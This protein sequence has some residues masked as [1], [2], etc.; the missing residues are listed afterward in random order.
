[1]RIP[2]LLAA[3]AAALGLLAGSIAA[4]S[5]AAEAAPRARW[6]LVA[7]AAAHAVSVVDASTGRITGA[8]PDAVLGTHAGVI[9]MGH[10]RVAF[11]DESGPRLD[12]VDITSSGVPRVASATP[13]PDAAGAW[14]RAGW[15]ADDPGHRFVA[16]G[17]DLDGSTTQQVT[18]LDTRRQLAR[19]ATIRTS[20][21]T[22]A[23]TG[24]R[25]TE[26]METFLVGS[27]L[28]LVVTAGGR[29]DAY[30]VAAILGGDA[31]PTPVATTPLGAYPHGPV[32]DARGT[33]IGSTLHDGIETVPLTRGGFG[34][35]LARPYPEPAVQSYRPRMAPDGETAVGT[36]TGTGPGAPTLLTSSSMRGAGVASV[37]LG[38]GTSTRA[39]VTPGYAAAVVTAGGV[40]TLSLVARGRAGLYDGAVTTVRLPALGQA[41]G[42]GSSARFLAASDD[43]SELFL[44]RAGTGSVLEI[45]VAG[46]RATVRGTIAVPSALADGGYLATVDPHQRPYDLSG[47]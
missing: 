17:S 26:E 28:R 43:G 2:S 45:D 10:G 14:T 37:A 16:V 36:Q 27:P 34:A 4:P 44:S 24:E 6:L 1:M 30:D 39:V 11:V 32:A 12:V 19:T 8:L 40:D 5:P 22:L 35:S 3:G 29:L 7:D 41:P 23:T 21:V 18:V 20:E 15:I 31:S 25:G 42:A 46:T 47:R 33:V 38:S 13:I 9:Q